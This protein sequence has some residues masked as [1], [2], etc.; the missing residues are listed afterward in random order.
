MT[1]NQQIA[2]CIVMLVGSALEMCTLSVGFVCK[3]VV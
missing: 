3:C 1:F 2:G